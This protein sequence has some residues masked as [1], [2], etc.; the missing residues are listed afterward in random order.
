MV[1]THNQVFLLPV[2]LYCI[3]GVNRRDLG[4]WPS[5]LVLRGK[6]EIMMLTGPNF[7]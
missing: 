3:N 2:D 5:V 4:E 6:K 1:S 7:P